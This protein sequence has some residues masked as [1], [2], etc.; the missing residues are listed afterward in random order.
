[1]GWTCEL[2]LCCETKN[3]YHMLAWKTD[4]RELE[5]ETKLKEIVCENVKFCIQLAKTCLGN[6]AL[7]YSRS[8]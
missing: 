6:V 4:T 8:E 3:R 7:C 5:N 1:M 2:G